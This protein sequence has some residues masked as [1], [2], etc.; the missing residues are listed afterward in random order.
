M[1][2][3]KRWVWKLDYNQEKYEKWEF[4]REGMKFFQQF[5]VCPL[6]PQSCK[7]QTGASLSPYLSLPVPGPNPRVGTSWNLTNWASSIFAVALMSLPPNL[8]STITIAPSLMWQTL[9]GL[10]LDYLQKFFILAQ[11]HSHLTWDT[12]WASWLNCTKCTP[13]PC[14]E[15]HIWLSMSY[16]NLL[17][18][19][20]NAWHTGCIVGLCIWWFNS[21]YSCWG[22]YSSELTQSP[23]IHQVKHL[24]SWLFSWGEP[25]PFTHH[26]SNGSESY[27]QHTI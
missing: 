6:L 4:K 20:S 23:W 24:F 11:M 17:Q 21:H 9:L 10:L 8:V 12:F 22:H 13:H 5:W 3:G 16:L 7:T 25:M 14:S 2:S 1:G 27:C 18:C 19:G 15:A 26:I